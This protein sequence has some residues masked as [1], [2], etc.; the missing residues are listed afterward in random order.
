[1][2]KVFYHLP[3]FALMLLMIV[4]CSG[5]KSEARDLVDRFPVEILSEPDDTGETFV[6]WE[7]SEDRTELSIETQTNYGQS[8]IVYEGDA[9]QV[10]DMLAYITIFVH[11]NESAADVALQDTLLDWQIQGARFESERFGRDRFDFALLNG[12]LLAYYQS[13]T[14]L[15]EV[16]LIPEEPDFSFDNDAAYLSL[17]N[18]ILLVVDSAS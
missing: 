15:F 6:W 13:G 7:L 5:P 9:D 17:F 11:A 16:R 4:A 3:V 2:R 12:G 8:T 10:E 14:T 18:A 1:M